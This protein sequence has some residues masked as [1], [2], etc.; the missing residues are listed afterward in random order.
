[1]T[2]SM[3]MCSAPLGIT[4]FDLL[5]G[6]G[7]LNWISNFSLVWFCNVFFATVSTVCLLN[8]FTSPVRVAIWKRCVF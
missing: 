8:K 5:G 7:H 1:M 6:Y 2:K 3:F 4:S